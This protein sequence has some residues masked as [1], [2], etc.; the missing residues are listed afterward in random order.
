MLRSFYSD[1]SGGKNLPRFRGGDWHPNFEELFG[2]ITKA[3]HLRRS[4]DPSNTPVQTP[5]QE[6]SF[7]LKFEVSK[8]FVPFGSVSGPR[9]V[10]RSLLEKEP[11]ETQTTREYC[12]Q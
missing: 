3:E 12:G 6:V 2:P 10:F 1:F 8:F 11:Q 5:S 9:F 4:L 7:G